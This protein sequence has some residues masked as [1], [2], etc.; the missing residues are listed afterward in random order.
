MPT[1]NWEV[2]VVGEQDTLS[3]QLEVEQKIKE[4][5]NRVPLDHW[6]LVAILLYSEV[7]VY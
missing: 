3:Q 4:Q 6:E 2:F 5:K 1:I 7:S